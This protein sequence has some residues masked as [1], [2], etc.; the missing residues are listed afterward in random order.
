MVLTYYILIAFVPV[1]KEATGDSKENLFLLNINCK[2]LNLRFPWN[3]HFPLIFVLNSEWFYFILI[4]LRTLNQSQN[5][6]SSL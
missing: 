6:V 5:W 3:V 4:A 2:V 1:H